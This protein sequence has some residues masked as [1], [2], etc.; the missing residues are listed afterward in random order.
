MKLHSAIQD[1]AILSNVGEIGEFRI[2]NSSKAFSILSSGLYA[3]KI[4][5]IIRELS[6]NAV[7]SHAAAGKKDTPFDVHLPSALE[8]W[9][10]IRDYGT[11]L[12]HDQVTNIYTTYFEST[13]TNSN[14]FIGALGLGSKS[15]F[16][17]TDNFTVTAVRD[18]RKGIYTAFINDQGV[19]S[20]ALMSEQALTDEPTGVE[21][22]FAVENS[23][24]F[25]K[26]RHE[27]QHVYRYFSLRPVISSPSFQFEVPEYLVMHIIPG[28]HQL[29][30][31]RGAY[32]IMG[33][34]A[35]PIDVPNADQALGLLASLVQNHGLVMHFNIGELD[36]QASREGLSYIPETIQAIKSKLEKVVAALEVKLTEEAD[37]ITNEWERALFLDSRY[38]GCRGMW[39]VAIANYISRTKFTLFDTSNSSWDRLKFFAFD[40]KALATKHNITIRGFTHRHYDNNCAREKPETSYDV[41]V[42]SFWRI[43]ISDSV[44][45]VINDTKVGAVERTKHFYRNNKA[46][47]G[48][49]TLVY[50][51]EP[52]DKTKPMNTAMFFAELRNPPESFIAK[53]SDIP[54]KPRANGVSANVTILKLVER[55]RSYYGSCDYVWNDAGDVTVFDKTK[56]YYYLPLS[57]YVSLGKIEDVKTLR[58][59]LIRAKVFTQELFGVRKT[60]LDWVKKQKNWVNIDEFVTETLEKLSTTFAMGLVKKSI[61]WQTVYQYNDCKHIAHPASPF[62]TLYEVFK[63]VKDSDSNADDSMKW[64]CLKYNVQ[65]KSK[66]SVEALMN[67]YMIQMMDLKTRYPLIDHI[68]MYRAGAKAVCEYVNLIDEKKGV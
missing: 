22:R 5:A 52:T 56:T 36:F 6:C 20:I 58:Q 17:Y 46:R 59:H 27:A 8:P 26:F 25:S 65:T 9:F 63:D 39:N 32:A 57:G 47:R 3:N 61:D 21:V 55:R 54:A 68:N 12:T 38:A 37:A 40:E 51:L 60:D 45:F 1:Q 29:K 43:R 53:A 48:Q 62:I 30:D 28:V 15:P 35:Y 33:N 31:S 24:D 2:R 49:N 18:G 66:V 50:V 7:D 23:Q 11:G 4:R 41:N 44:R 13:K 67:K 64:L 34:I 42:N 14:D 10:S 16:S 19:P